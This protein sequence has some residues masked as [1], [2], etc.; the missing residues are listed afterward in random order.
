MKRIGLYGGS[1]DPVHLGH[2]AVAKA[3][4]IQLGL[5]QLRW[6]P[7]GEPWQKPRG[8]APAHHRVAMLQLAVDVE[9]SHV[10]DTR[11]IDRDGPTYTIDTLESLARDFPAAD[12]EWHLIIGQDQFAALHTWHRWRDIVARVHF[13]VVAR[14]GKLAQVS[15]EVRPTLPRGKAIEMTPMPVSSTEIRRR[16][17]A[18][19]SAA[20]LAP[21]EV[22]RYIA[23]HGLYLND[24]NAAVSTRS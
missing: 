13:G 18:G 23:R 9:P 16:V 17:A 24:R 7:A 15:D 22:A 5:D 12:I 19:G 3:A 6:L 21:E 2:L 4:Q 20:G 11:E 10:I 8:L 14:A 1:F